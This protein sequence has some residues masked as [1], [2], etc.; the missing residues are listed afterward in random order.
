[1]FFVARPQLL[2]KFQ[3]GF[4]HPKHLLGKDE[5][6]KFRN[7]TH[8]SSEQPVSWMSWWGQYLA[9]FLSETMNGSGNLQILRALQGIPA[10]KAAVRQRRHGRRGAGE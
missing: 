7:V 2:I 5:I 9:T 4:A 6:E 10:T 3:S 1:M 8:N